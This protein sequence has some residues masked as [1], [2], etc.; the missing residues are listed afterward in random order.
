VAKTIQKPSSKHP[1][2]FVEA[3][4]CL[5]VTK[6]PEGPDWEYEIKF[7]GYRAIGIK[8]GGRVGLMSRNGNDFS[9]RFPSI[10]NASRKEWELRTFQ[11]RI[12]CCQESTI[13]RDKRYSRKSLR[14]FVI[15]VVIH[16]SAVIGVGVE[17]DPST[18]RGFQW[19]RNKLGI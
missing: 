8:S 1:A 7:D 16:D 2:R 19:V 11:S 9:A 10:A 3:M 12:F 17:R 6:L 13:L 14:S 15:H 5:A 4:Q 18:T